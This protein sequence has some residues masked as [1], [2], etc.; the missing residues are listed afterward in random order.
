[1]RAAVGSWVLI[2]VFS[3]LVVGAG[4][5]GPPVTGAAARQ[6]PPP[7]PPVGSCVVGT[8]APEVVPCDT[9]HDGEIV[10]TWTGDAPT[11]ALD[12]TRFPAADYPDDDPQLHCWQAA[13]DYIDLTLPLEYSAGLRWYPSSLSWQTSVGH[14]PVTSFVD[15]WSWSACIVRSYGM[16]GRAMT[17][18]MSV[19]DLGQDPTGGD[20]PDDWRTCVRDAEQSFDWLP[21]TEPHRI[22]LVASGELAVPEEADRRALLEQQQAY[23]TA[24]QSP[25]GQPMSDRFLQ[26]P[27]FD[28]DNPTAVQECHDLVDGYLGGGLE[29]RDDLRPV[30]TWTSLYY[31]ESLSVDPMVDVPVGVYG[32][33]SVEVVGDRDLLGSVAGVGSG[34]L[35]YG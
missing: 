15:D 32:E 26:R 34:P 17:S 1:M 2:L 23:A 5:G 9:D 6:A 3:A 10:L 29:E 4:L 35:P 8:R 20:L 27:R 21:C 31:G 7:P 33:C 14:G 18:T 12:R 19:R 16:D 13:T 30:L 24:Q 25:V 22:E 28:L 11:T